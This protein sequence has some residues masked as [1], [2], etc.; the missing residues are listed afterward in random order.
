[1]G[2][3]GG[4]WERRWLADQYRHGAFRPPVG[5]FAGVRH[6]LP[7][8]VFVVILL[9]IFEVTVARISSPGDESIRAGV[10]LWLR[11]WLAMAGSVPP[12]AIPAAL[13]GLL[14]IGTLWRWS[15]RPEQLF[16]ALFGV[17]LE[18]TVFGLALWMICL[19]APALLEQ[20]G[21]SLGAING[22]DPRLITFIGV[23]VYEE[24]VFRMILFS[25]LARLLHV[26][27]VP[28][29]LA[30]PLAIAISAAAFASAHYLVQSEPFVP[31]VFAMRCVIGVFL[32]LVFWA[33]GMGV[34][35]GAHIVY[36]VIVSLTHE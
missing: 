17:V 30:V 9:A 20:S 34:A 18:G 7:S 32:A 35:I 14:V 21:L 12:I 2:L 36:D 27:F 16:V 1:M 4:Y 28:W 23:G 31:I 19:N 13:I 22:L 5:Y 6:P 33:R 24:A 11:D 15:E 10:E 26:I 29:L 3:M 8:L 25:W